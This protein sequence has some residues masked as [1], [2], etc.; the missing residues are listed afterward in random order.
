[1]LNKQ[2]KSR[3]W[4]I[5]TDKVLGFDKPPET[6]YRCEKCKKRFLVSIRHDGVYIL[7]KHKKEA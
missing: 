7:S 5:Q 2:K 4:C 6:R 1:M 3:I